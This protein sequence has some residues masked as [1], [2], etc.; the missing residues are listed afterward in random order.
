[1]VHLGHKISMYYFSCSGGPSVLSIKS[2]LQNFLSGLRF[3]HLV[4]LWVT[5]H[6][7]TSWAGKYPVGHVTPDMCFF[8][9]RWERYR[10]HKKHVGTRYAEPVFF[11]SGG[12]YGSRNAFWCVRGTKHQR[13]IFHTP[14]G[15]VRFPKKVSQETL[16]RICVFA[17]SRTCGS[18]HEKPSGEFHG[19]IVMSH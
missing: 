8:M 2:P 19:L 7:S 5:V 6:S 9:L 13:T 17:S 11:S 15:R 10:L 3:L 18:L 12:I 14:V 16:R 4:D 1:M